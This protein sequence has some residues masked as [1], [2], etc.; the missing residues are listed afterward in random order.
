MPLTGLDWNYFNWEQLEYYGDLNLMK[1]GIVFADRVT[2][3]SP[4]YAKEITR[5]EHGCGLDALLAR[6][7][8]DLIGIVNG[9]SSNL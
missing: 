2:T 9:V 3:V 4:T 7:G 8:T 6:R 5:P 1:S